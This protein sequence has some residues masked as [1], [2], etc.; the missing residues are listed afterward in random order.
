[1]FVGVGVAGM[2]NTVSLEESLGV[3][4]GIEESKRFRLA[5]A[6]CVPYDRSGLFIL[7]FLGKG[8]CKVTVPPLL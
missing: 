3:E 4:R 5:V 7:F 8:V 6:T 2:V 1:V